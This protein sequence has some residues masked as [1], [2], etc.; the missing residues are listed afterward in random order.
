[1]NHRDTWDMLALADQQ[2]A[3]GEVIDA[4]RELRQ[5]AYAEEPMDVTFDRLFD[6][7]AALDALGPE[8]PR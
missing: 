3:I 7:V 8:A 5:L 6:A 2:A 1:M 4:A